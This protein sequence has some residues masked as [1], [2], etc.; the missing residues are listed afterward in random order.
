VKQRT[1]LKKEIC[2]IKTTQN[3]KQELNKGME[4]FRKKY[5]T[6]ILEI[7]SFSQKKKKHSG[8]PLQQTRTSR[9]QNLRAQ[10]L[11]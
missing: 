7:K 8:R 1:L 9:R 5:K 2:E 4:N 3:V 11:K 10:R 6:E